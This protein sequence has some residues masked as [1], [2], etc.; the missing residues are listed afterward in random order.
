MVINVPEIDQLAA[1]LRSGLLD[2][3]QFLE[4]SVRLACVKVNC[5]RTGL[6]KFVAPD[7]RRQLKCL[8]MYDKA[9][10]RM[11]QVEDRSE[12]GA[13]AYFD[14]L[15]RRGH[16]LAHDARSHAATKAFFET[17]LRPR[18]VRS[19]M[20]VCFALNGKLYGALTC[21]QISAEI[22]WT[23]TQLGTLLRIGARISLGLAGASPRQLDTF[24]APL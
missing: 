1:C 9:G 4:A 16:V 11:V 15:Q 20:A 14:E 19:L 23:P 8:A 6:W 2:R 18:G 7:G 24:I 5:C 22:R 10:D 21:T 13:T 17:D 3:D 12:D